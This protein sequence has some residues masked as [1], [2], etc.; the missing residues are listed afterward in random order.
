MTKPSFTDFDRSYRRGV[1]L[2]LSLAELFIIL[3]F[4]LLL[5]MIGYAATQRE[6][7]EAEGIA[8]QDVT[9]DLRD[10]LRRAEEQLGFKIEDA[11]PSDLIV[12]REEEIEAQKQEIERLED[13]L[14][15]VTEESKELS[16][17]REEAEA[18]GVEARDIAD[19][20]RDKLKR[21]EKQLGFKI[22]RL[23]DQLSQA[24]EE[25]E[26]AKA[27]LEK[28]EIRL[29]QDSPC[30]YKMGKRAN[31]EDYEK[32]LYAFNIRISDDS[33]FVKDIPAPTPEYQTQKEDLKFDRTALDRELG[34]EEFEPAFRS[35][36]LAGDNKK[37]RQD[38]RCT[39][40]VRVW[41]ATGATNKQGYKQAH[42]RIVQG[43]FNTYEF[44]DDPWPH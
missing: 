3:I 39:F 30:W 35:W 42:N 26:A 18:A 4:L 31:G 13:Q 2:G 14:L 37:I 27:E 15:Q 17:Q 28:F 5:A 44:K 8:A 20:L 10:K 32:A 7:M 22:E 6:E 19:D 40:S 16:E 21:A 9:D 25:K 38:R 29:G 41:D 36:K 43:V 1:V 34:Y 24:T 12:A 23:E 33:I 11:D